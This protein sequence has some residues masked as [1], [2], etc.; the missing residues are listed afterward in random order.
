MRV[1]LFKVLADM[2][3]RIAVTASA[4]D[5]RRDFFL[6]EADLQAAL[7]FGMGAAAGRPAAPS[8]AGTEN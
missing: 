2:R 7:T 4:L 6:A 8:V 3:T 5:A 1:D